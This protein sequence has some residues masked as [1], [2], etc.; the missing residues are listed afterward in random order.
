MPDGSQFDP[1]VVQALP[2]TGMGGLIR[3]DSAMSGHA[4]PLPYAAM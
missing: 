4:I 3:D 2:Q 1:Q